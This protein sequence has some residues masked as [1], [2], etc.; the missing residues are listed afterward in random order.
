MTGVWL[1]PPR[2]P[3]R[4]GPPLHRDRI[5]A[6]A[7]ELL[8]REGVAGLTMRRLAERLGAGSTTLYWHVTNKDD[9]LDLALDQIFGEVLLPE[10]DSTTT[11]TTVAT[12]DRTTAST[13]TEEPPT[14]DWRA[15]VETLLLGWRAAMLRHPWSAALVGRPLLGPNVLTRTEFLQS[16]LRRAG[17]VEPDLSA[18]T[19]ALANYVIGAAVTL[20][21]WRRLGD[22]GSRQAARQHLAAQRERYPT[23]VETGHL[24]DRD[25]DGTFRRGLAYLL[26]GLPADRR[27]GAVSGGGA[28]GATGR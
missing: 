1:R 25:E 2:S 14:G 15:D 6:A 12:T 18:A 4:S 20:S 5:V 26:D 7:V 10:P 23:L 27:P 19:H 9:V 11:A 24:D 13:T 8:D 16:A 17:L 3:G 28:S 21:S 22:P